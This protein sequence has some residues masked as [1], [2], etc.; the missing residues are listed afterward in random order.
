MCFVS[1]FLNMSC[2]LYMYIC[3]PQFLSLRLSLPLQRIAA[4]GAN[5]QHH[6]LNLVLVDERGFGCCVR[7][8]EICI[9]RIGQWI[10]L[11]NL[12]LE[13]DKLL[14]HLVVVALRQD[15]QY[16]P[17]RFVHLDAFRQGQPAR[18]GALWMGGF[19]Q[20]THTHTHKLR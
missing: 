10:L 2:S 20:E 4:A 16:R 17:A 8:C 13:L 5:S 19:K 15:A 1:Y 3:Y 18:T 6:P 12:G 11:P 7:F 14:G 9:L